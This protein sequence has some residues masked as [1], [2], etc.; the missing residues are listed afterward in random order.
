MS[1]EYDVI[2][3]GGGPAGLTAGIYCARANKSVLVLEKSTCGGKIIETSNV[4]N[5]P[6]FTCIS[7]VDFADKLY[8]QA[9][10]C[11]VDIGEGMEVLSI[12]TDSNSCYV[13]TEDF[14][15]SC[16]AC[17]IATGTKNRVL[18]I[19]NEDKLIGDKISFCVTCDGPFY[20]DKTVAVIG[21]GNSAVTEALELA[22]IAKKVYIVQDLMKLTAEQTLIG[23]LPENV[24]VL[25]S[26][27]VIEYK[28]NDDKFAGLKIEKTNREIFDTWFELKEIEC[29]GVF[30]AIGL[31]PQNEFLND[32]NNVI[33]DNNGYILNT[34]TQT[35]D[36]RIFACGDCASGTKKQVAVACGSGATAAMNA[37]DYLRGL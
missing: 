11:G 27:R 10:T 35:D 31:I 32:E 8:E 9:L 28:M 24:E 6:G 37:L 22:E 13:H 20:K 34:C 30:M 4:E 1:I 33:L 19:E 18:G 25:T 26:S 15:Y 29:D 12:K 3:V 36:V 14:D 7:G 2:I 16:K 23:R 5:I 17:I 21:G